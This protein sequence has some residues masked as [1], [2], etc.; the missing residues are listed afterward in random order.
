M[1]SLSRDPPHEAATTGADRPP[2]PGEAPPF[3]IILHQPEIPGNTGNIIR[4]CAAAGAVL[5]LVGPLGFRLDAAALRR[6]GMDY[7]Q[8]ADCRRHPDWNAYLEQEPAG[9]RRFAL[10]T[11]GESRPDEHAFRPGDR[12]LFGSESSG[13]PQALLEDHPGRRLR[14]PMRTDARSLNLAN[15]VAILLYEALRQNHFPG[16]R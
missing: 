9:S 5:H 15:S 16:L 10:T 6:A 7:R 1:N 11:R 12:F 14:I 8:L 4:L 13:L 2:Q 3:H